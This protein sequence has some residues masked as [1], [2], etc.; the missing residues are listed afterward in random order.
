M[1]DFFLSLLLLGA[2]ST[3]GPLPFWATANHYGMMPEGSGALALVQAGGSS[4]YRESAV[5]WYWGTMLGADL[6]TYHPFAAAGSGAGRTDGAYGRVKVGELYAGLKWKSLSLDVGQKRRERFFYGAWMPDLGPLSVT[7][8]R[9]A[10]SGNARPV[11]GYTLSLRPWAVPFTQERVWLFGSYGDYLTLDDRYTSD[12]LLHAMQMGVRIRPMWWLDVSAGLDHYALWGGT[13]PENGPMPLTLSNYFRVC[14]GM[15]GTQDAS[16]SDR[17]NV[18]GE[19]GGAEF[20][21]LDW[22]L[23]PLW[24]LVFQHDIP[25][26]DKS[27][28]RFQNFPDGVNTLHL[29]RRYNDSSWVTDILYEYHYTMWQSGTRH[30]RPTTEEERAEL[31]PSDPFHY[32][33][34]ILGGGDDYFNNGEYRTA[35]TYFGRTIGTPIFFPTGTHAGTWDPSGMTLGVE[36][37]RIKAHHFAIAG[38]LFRRAP[39]RLM[40]TYSRNYG[41]YSAPYTG[42][43]QWN[44]DPGTVKETPLR[45]VSCGMNGEIPLSRRLSFDACPLSVL[46]GLYADRG[47]LLPDNFGA[48]LGLRWRLY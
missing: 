6:D 21:R 47:E 40:L 18:L 48:T 12:A 5:R 14:L 29:T 36:N 45:Q 37:N 20:I 38:K 33:N 3:S 8:G 26:N 25:Y 28:M 27:G 1:N 4:P 30:D 41:I 16:H 23:H 35:W 17:V 24:D 43:S 22:H 46:W 13:H 39:Y 15:H 2:M 42:E 10:W 7:G 32:W 31:D 44:H 19:Q 9:L 11:P 34:H